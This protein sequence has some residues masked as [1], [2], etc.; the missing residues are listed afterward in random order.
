[1]PR[2]LVRGA[3]GSGR[4]EEGVMVRKC[5]CIQG[6]CVDELFVSVREGCVN[7][8]REGEQARGEGEKRGYICGDG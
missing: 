4:R 8:R 3:E 1:M 7:K 5:A 2:R 6:M